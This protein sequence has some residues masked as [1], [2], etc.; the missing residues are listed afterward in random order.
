MIR[1]KTF[2]A[3]YSS[4]A[5]TM[6]FISLNAKPSRPSRKRPSGLSGLFWGW[7][8]YAVGLQPDCVDE[9]SWVSALAMLA[10]F[11]RDLQT[12][13]TQFRAARIQRFLLDGLA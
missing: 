11:T 6:A 9:D 3:E 8:R 2:A 5:E 1:R 13:V 7:V 12:R 10:L 4:E